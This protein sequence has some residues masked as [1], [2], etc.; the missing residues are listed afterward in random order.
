MK[1]WIQHTAQDFKPQRLRDERALPSGLTELEQ[2]H[3]KV[4]SEKSTLQLYTLQMMK[5]WSGPG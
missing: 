2:L 1:Q 5:S 4:N 3:L